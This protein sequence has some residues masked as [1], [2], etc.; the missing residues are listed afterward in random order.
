MIQIKEYWGD[1]YTLRN[2]QN[3]SDF[4]IIF[5]SLIPND[6]IKLQETSLKRVF[7]SECLL[8]EFWIGDVRKRGMT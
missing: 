7:Q 6:L 2:H 4:T 5:I 8:K 1:F 3:A